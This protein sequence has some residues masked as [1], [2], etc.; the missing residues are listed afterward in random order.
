MNFRG[1]ADVSEPFFSPSPPSL[2]GIFCILVKS[3]SPLLLTLVLAVALPAQA[4]DTSECPAGQL[5]P[6]TAEAS[7][8]SD[9][10]PEKSA[11]DWAKRAKATNATPAVSVSPT[12]EAE[13][14]VQDRIEE[15]G[16][17]VVHFWGP[18]CSSS[19]NELD[20]GWKTLVADNPNVTFTFVSACNDNENGAALL[21]DYA[22]P[23]RVA[24]VTQ[25]DLGPSGNEASRRHSFL[26]LPV[27]R[28]P[29][30]WI[31]HRNGELAFAMN[32]GTMEMDTI[33]SLLDAT[34][35]DG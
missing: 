28:I 6:I 19:P 12:T 10:A 15:E 27:T 35:K 11:T 34:S 30:T 24:D 17:H 29:S 26:S 33:Q 14:F 21:D 4:Q 8:K 31:F 7:S 2:T 3:V 18:R 23:N 20:N 1:P 13:A 9:N 22:L 32:Y 25:P 5:Q 16:L